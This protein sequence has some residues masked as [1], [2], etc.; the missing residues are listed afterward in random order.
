MTTSLLTISA[1]KESLE[2]HV[3]LCALRYQE[4]ELRLT[5]VETKID[6]VTNRVE[7]IKKDIKT[8]LIQAVSAI[9]IALI[10]AT[11]TICGVILSHIK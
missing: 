2:T 4:L 7:T 10:G 9:I 1:E 3:E 5:V 11:G 8:S 6:E